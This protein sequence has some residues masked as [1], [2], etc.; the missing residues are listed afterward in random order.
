MDASI[1]TQIDKCY[2]LVEKKKNNGMFTKTTHITKE[3][4][5][6]CSLW[7]GVSQTRMKPNKDV[8]TCG[9]NCT[10]YIFKVLQKTLWALLA[11]M[12]YRRIWMV[13]QKHPAW[14]VILKNIG[15]WV[16]NRRVFRRLTYS[17]RHL[18]KCFGL[19]FLMCCSFREIWLKMLVNSVTLFRTEDG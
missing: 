18:A 8:F 13:P 4:E 17:L 6:P 3:I 15:Q 10:C 2:R 19:K 7:K 5:I 11:P 9:R 16:E 1:H 14:I 12:V